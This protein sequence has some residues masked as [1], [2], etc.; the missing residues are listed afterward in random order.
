[1]ISQVV[2]N[3]PKVLSCDFDRFLAT[4]GTVAIDKEI[5]PVENDSVYTG[6]NS[7]LEAP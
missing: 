3:V 4:F 5:H 2:K 6:T 1:L 7:N